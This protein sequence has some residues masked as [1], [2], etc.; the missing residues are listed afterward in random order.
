MQIYGLELLVL[1]HY[2]DK[3]FDHKHCDGGDIIILLCRVTS[4]KHMFKRL[5]EFMGGSP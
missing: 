2:A 3:S 4:R 5:R 1:C